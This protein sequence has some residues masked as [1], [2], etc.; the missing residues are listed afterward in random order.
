M[1]S[2]K[3][4]FM[5]ALYEWILDNNCTPYIVVDATLPFVEVP[6]QFITEG[7]IILNIL[8]SATHN[9]YLGDEWITFSARFSGVSEEINIPIGAVVAIY[10]QENGEGMGFETEALPEDYF[11]ETIIK[12]PS[13][14]THH[15]PQLNIIETEIDSA[16]QEEIKKAPIASKE[17]SIKDT[18]STSQKKEDPKKNKKP[19][20]TIIK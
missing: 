17:K 2:N 10:A 1:T 3:P 19:T 6:E 8:P 4:Y 9:L 12:I 7:K 15:K 14:T 5:R 11:D 20:L 13:K 18:R 16:E